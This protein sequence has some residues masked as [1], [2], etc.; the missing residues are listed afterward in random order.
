[1]SGRAI[2]FALVLLGLVL[3]ACTRGGGG[4]SEP[5]AGIDKPVTVILPAPD[6][7]DFRPSDCPPP[8]ASTEEPERHST[9]P[10]PRDF[11]A[12]R[13]ERRCALVLE[14]SG[15]A[16]K[17]LRVEDGDFVFSVILQ[18]APLSEFPAP[19][20]SNSPVLKLGNETIFFN[21]AWANIYRTTRS[22]QVTSDPT[23][24]SC[25]NC[26][27]DGRRWLEAIWYDEPA[28]VLY[29]WYHM[30]P[31]YLECLTA[32]LI[33][34][35]VSMDLGLTWEDRGIVLESGHPIDC[36]YENAYF[37]GGNGDFSVILDRDS[38][39]FYFLFSNY[40]GPVEEQGV[41]IARGAFADRGQPG[42]LFKYF[43]GAW[44]EPGLGGRV[45]PLWPTVTGWAGPEFD[46]FWGPSVHWNTALGAYVVL[47]NRA[48]DAAWGQGGVYLSVSRDLLT[49]TSPVKLVETNA[50][51]P[52]VVG[53]GPRG[54][55][56]SVGAVARLY[57]A[58]VSTFFLD[59]TQE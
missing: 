38:R 5:E 56:S 43:E 23:L 40:A 25:L 10:P 55:D 37:A 54:T 47:L 9:R 11:A 8:G 50:F 26:S 22:Q 20:D 39:H 28:G 45:T 51:Y 33:G 14:A 42:T 2:G 13:R 1:V 48:V 36:S 3:L 52:Q 59:F 49:W 57:V 32:P 44:E 30:E 18:E 29:G 31:D 16:I 34:A 6:L 4:E 15:S 12:F 7:E 53:I 24:S 17:Q 19:V 21:S 35:M 41:G 58:G 46:V 27:A